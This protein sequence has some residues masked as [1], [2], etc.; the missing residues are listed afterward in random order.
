MKRYLLLFSVFL[1]VQSLYAQASQHPDVEQ[2]CM[3]YI[4]GFYQGDTAK[5][6]R[7]LSPDLLKFGYWKNKE[8]G[9]YESDGQ[10]TF[11]EALDYSRNVL[12]KQRFVAKEAPRKVEVLDVGNHI[13]SAKVTA[14][15]GIDYLLLAKVDDR[16]VIQQ[17]LWEGPLK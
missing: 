15:W 16:W 2:A 9:V 5:I 8:T 6:I 1:A 7:S 3:D 14:W 12:V 13:A 17:V 11:T 4:D 10:M